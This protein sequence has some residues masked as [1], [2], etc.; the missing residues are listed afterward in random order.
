MSEGDNENGDAIVIEMVYPHPI[1]RVWR[2]LT[3][4]EA[5]AAWLMPNDFE[6]RLGHQFT[7]RAAPQEGWN[8]MVHCQV[9][10]LDAPHRVA[11]TWLG[12]DGLLDT[13]VTFRLEPTGEGKGTRLRLEHTGFAA[14]GPAGLTIRDILASGWDSKLLREQLPALL[15]QL[16]ARDK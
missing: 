15:D 14:G 9:T 16:A 13:L 4:R 1:E 3:S 12:G 7:F 10:A 11:Y 2:A 5:L 8:G 6:P